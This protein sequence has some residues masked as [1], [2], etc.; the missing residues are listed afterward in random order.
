RGEVSV[1]QEHF[2]SSLLRGRLLGLARD[3]GKGIGPSAILACAPGEQHDLGLIAFGLALRARGW[4]IVFLGADT[5]LESVADAARTCDPTIV[6]MSAVDGR[7]FRRHADALARL[8][9]EARLCLGGPGAAKARVEADIVLL[10][11]G[12]VE[13]AERLTQLAARESPSSDGHPLRHVELNPP[14]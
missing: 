7:A 12:P 14:D 13:E 3:W 2:A 6:V 11:G 8:A 5:P 10:T 9:R 1:A 4:R